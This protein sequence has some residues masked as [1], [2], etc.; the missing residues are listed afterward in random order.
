[1]LVFFNRLCSIMACWMS[2]SDYHLTILAWSCRRQ[3][4]PQRGERQLQLKNLYF[5]AQ[6]FSIIAKQQLK[7]SRSSRVGESAMNITEVEP[8]L[9]CMF[10]FFIFIGL[11]Q[12]HRCQI[13]RHLN[14]WHFP[15]Q[16][17]SPDLQ[18][19]WLDM[20]MATCLFLLLA[21]LMKV[22]SSTKLTYCSSVHGRHAGTVESVKS[23]YL[24]WFVYH[25]CVYNL[26]HELVQH[27]AQW[28]SGSL[29]AHYFLV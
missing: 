12:H 1:M 5:M 6:D 23:P 13:H 25:D 18:W 3:C 29:S 15:H 7:P 26:G 20:T 14:P 2:S 24:V 10:L 9:Y 28:V 8:S 19:T 22:S 11:P 27:N 4:L 16:H 21:S 17:Q